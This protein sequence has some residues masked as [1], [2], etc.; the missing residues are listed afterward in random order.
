M[1]TPVPILAAC[2][3]L[4]ACGAPS[5]PVAEPAPQEPGASVRLPA[6]PGRPGAGYLSLNIQGDHGALVS[7]TSPQAGRIEMHE[8]MS[9]GGHMSGMRPLT[10]V[11]VRDGETL[12][13]APGGRHLMLYDLAEGLAPGGRVVLTFHF[14]RGPPETVEAVAQP[15]GGAAH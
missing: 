1:K 12:R 15:A 13:F 5:D 3:A 14:E 4:A 9:G 7:V 11:P 8:T 10:R 2:L 6:V